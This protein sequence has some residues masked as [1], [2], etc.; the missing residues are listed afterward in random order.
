MTRIAVIH[1]TILSHQP[2]A[3]AFQRLWP[4]ATTTNLTDDS[5]STD[6]AASD[7]LNEDNNGRYLVSHS[8]YTH[9]RIVSWCHV[10]GSRG[11]ARVLAGGAIVS[12]TFGL[13]WTCRTLNIVVTNTHNGNRSKLARQQEVQE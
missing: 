3:E 9:P 11:I 12:Q 6:L 7:D 13:H 2:I 10:P 1:A 8:C 4:E 5:L